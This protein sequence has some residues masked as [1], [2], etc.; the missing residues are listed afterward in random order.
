MVARV[1]KELPAVVRVYCLLALG[2][3]IVAGCDPGAGARKKMEGPRAPTWPALEALRG[4]N[5][6]MSVGMSLQMEGP[7][8]AKLAATAPTFKQLLD[9]FEKQPIPSA[10]STTARETAKKDLVETLRKL[11]QAAS[12]DE[13]KA[14]WEQATG[15]MKTVGTP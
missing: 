10:F 9:D 8:A 6:M 3:L 2:A 14:L 7:A 1:G 5:G 12:D 11:P 13:I 15:S 4:E